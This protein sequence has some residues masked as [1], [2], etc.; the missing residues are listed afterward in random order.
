M[1]AACTS[2]SKETLAAMGLGPALPPHGSL[3]CSYWAP[4]KSDL[5]A[6][7]QPRVP[8][9]A[10]TSLT[11]FNPFPYP[12]AAGQIALRVYGSGPGLPV[13]TLVN[14]GI[15]ANDSDLLAYLNTTALPWLIANGFTVEGAGAQFQLAAPN[16]VAPKIGGSCTM[17]IVQ[18]APPP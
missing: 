11:T 12:F 15:I 6:G 9:C 1:S 5:V 13:N 17:Q 8:C 2:T 16:I 14:P 7:C 4:A 18:P 10:P 3:C